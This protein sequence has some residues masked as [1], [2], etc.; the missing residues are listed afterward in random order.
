[1]GETA[2]DEPAFLQYF[3]QL[4][5]QLQLL[6][7]HTLVVIYYGYGKLEVF[8]TTQALQELKITRL[9]AIVK[10]DV[11]VTKICKYMLYESSQRLFCARRKPVSQLLPPW[12]PPLVLIIM[13]KVGYKRRSS[14]FKKICFA[15]EDLIWKAFCWSVLRWVGGWYKCIATADFSSS[16]FPAFCSSV[17]RGCSGGNSSDGK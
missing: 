3:L 16:H 2:F 17:L 15:I 7:S 14:N 1:M 10:N 11:F 8:T 9:Y 13:S 5:L 4:Q 12:V 6:A